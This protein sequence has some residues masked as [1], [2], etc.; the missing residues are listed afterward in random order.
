MT[1]NNIII[2][3]DTEFVRVSP[4]ICLFWAFDKEQ[5]RMVRYRSIQL[6][7]RVAFEKL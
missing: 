2:T 6:G 4:G 5:R 1:P 7:D 3:H